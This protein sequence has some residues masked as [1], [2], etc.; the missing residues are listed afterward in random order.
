MEISMEQLHYGVVRQDGAWT[1]IGDN[2]RF[3]AY[4]SREEAEQAAERLARQS[5]GLPVRL[6]VQNEAGELASRP[7]TVDGK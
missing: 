1:I 4:A 2:L 6:H 7:V 5:C 3:G